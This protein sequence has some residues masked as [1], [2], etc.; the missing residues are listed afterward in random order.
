MSGP[1]QW[2]QGGFVPANGTLP[3]KVEVRGGFVADDEDA[4]VQALAPKRAPLPAPRAQAL[5]PKNVVAMAKARLRDV[6]AELRRL[7]ALEKEKGELERLIA[8]A[9]SKPTKSNLREIKRSTG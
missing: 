5:S 9:E 6:K 1:L 8:A 3:I 7:K 2:T 4:P